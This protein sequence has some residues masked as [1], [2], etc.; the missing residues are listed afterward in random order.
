MAIW[1]LFLPPSSSLF[2]TIVLPPLTSC[3][4]P[5]PSTHSLVP[6]LTGS[7]HVA[8]SLATSQAYLSFHENSQNRRNNAMVH[9]NQAGRQPILFHPQKYVCCFSFQCKACICLPSQF[10]FCEPV[11]NAHLEVPTDTYYH[12][13]SWKVITGRE[14]GTLL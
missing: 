6:H 5:V 7:V 9:S 13:E 14:G 1:C 8:R 3:G 12:K 10:H 4:S 11:L 2:K